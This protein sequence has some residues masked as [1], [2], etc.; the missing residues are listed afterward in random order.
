M[1]VRKTIPIK[2]H[3]HTCKNRVSRKKHV[4][5]M[6]VH[7]HSDEGKKVREIEAEEETWKFRSHV[8]TKEIL[9]Q[10]TKCYT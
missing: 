8:H 9:L 4:E 7:V 10:N 1:S 3:V 5:H 6:H 2:I